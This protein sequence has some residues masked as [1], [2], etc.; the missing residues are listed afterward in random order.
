MSKQ[1]E[2]V[3]AVITHDELILCAQRGPS[4]SL[5]GLWEFPG[6]KLEHGESPETALRREILEELGCTVDVGEQVTVTKHVYEFGEVTLRT[7]YC[8]IVEGTPTRSEH[9]ALQW[10]ERDQLQMLAWAPADIPAVLLVEA[11]GRD[12]QA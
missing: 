6:G 3:G 12:D 9:S 1:I 2:V 8:R 4:G 10:L 11:K 7:Y 5:A